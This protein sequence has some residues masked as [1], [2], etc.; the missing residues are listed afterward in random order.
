MRRELGF[1]AAALT[2]LA[3][4]VDA[5]ADDASLPPPPAVVMPTPFDRLG[6]N[7]VDAFTGWNLVYYGGAVAASGTMAF[8]GADH[9]IRVFTQRHLQ[10]KA[11]ADT[12]LYAGYILPIVVA[13]GI[14]V[15]GLAANDRVVTG[16]ASAALQALAVTSAT[17]VL[18]KWGIGRP[19]PTN[20]GDPN[21]PERLTHSEYARQLHP[22]NFKG[23]YAW[24]SGHVSSTISIA[25]ALT[26]YYPDHLWI[27]LVGY[28]LALLIGAALVD[29]DRHWTS[30]LVAGA[31]IGHAIG[32]S[33]GRNFRRMV[34][35]GKT[36]D[37]S[38]LG[39]L[40]L[41]PLAGA[42]YG[43]AVGSSF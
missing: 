36:A 8:S 32:Y 12:A 1:A 28:P 6:P 26:G 9:E 16:A 34:R 2:L 18:L 21:D 24:P 39:S 4:P 7:L 41:R 20:G 3:S 40:T 27:P 37:G 19:F 38:V 23:D 11:L 43:L 5:S 25:A 42:T 15:I 13:P 29:G 17:T 35:E 30:D 31:L 22:F 10:A 14:Y 33:I